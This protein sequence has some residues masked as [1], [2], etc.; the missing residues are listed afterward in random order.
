MLNASLV[1]YLSKHHTEMLIKLRGLVEI[2]SGSYDKAG[3]DRA[4]N[5]MARELNRLGFKT[6]N[7]PDSQIGTLIIAERVFGGKGKVLILGH[8]DTVWPFGTLK[9]WPFTIT[10]DGLAT[11]PGVGDMK[12]GLIVALAAIEALEACH[13]GHFESITFVLIPDEEL[14]SVHTRTIIEAQGRKADWA[15][16]MEPGRPNGGVVT[17]RGAVGALYLRARGRTAHCGGNFSEGVS[18]IRELSQ[19]VG[20]IE[21]LSTPEKDRILNVGIFR[22]GEA[23]QVVPA[24]AEMHID[25]RAPND[26]E[27]NQLIGR[28]R[29]IA[30]TSTNPQVELSL[31]GG[32]TRPAFRRTA[33]V[34]DLYQ[35]ASAI[36][37]EM[38]IPLPEIHSRAGSDANLVAGQGT[39]TLDGLGPIAWDVCS[40]RERISVQSLGQ[41]ALL[42]ANLMAGL[43][44][45]F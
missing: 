11:G 37:Q 40:R 43:K 16:V 19:K 33:D 17:S 21:S 36:A 42:L 18:A 38:K 23:R 39:P 41:R 22:G 7:M 12:G 24:E 6:E 5:V 31:T 34:L 32:L 26:E 35:R 28:L 10:N 15:L 29:E 1:S 45:E 44:S 8:L 25:L 14:G 9:E 27:A 3:V 2:E 4:G 20:L 30:L 13:L